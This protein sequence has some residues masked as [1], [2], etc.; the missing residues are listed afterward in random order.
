L[1][2]CGRKGDEEGEIQGRG[3]C[4]NVTF[5]LG[6]Q[7][8]AMRRTSNYYRIEL[9]PLKETRCI[10][11]RGL[12]D[13]EHPKFFSRPSHPMQFS[14]SIH[15]IQII[16]QRNDNDH[17][18]WRDLFF[19]LETALWDGISMAEKSMPVSNSSNSSS[20]FMLEKS[21]PVSKLIEFIVIFYAR[22]I[23]ACIKLIEF[24]AIVVDHA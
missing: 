24:I 18:K 11:Q 22:E 19:A 15:K 4:V 9:F 2:S 21:M 12:V 23:Y 13:L 1:E 17:P 20:F 7:A 10:I 8:T 14:T 16:E 3:I 5:N 6:Q